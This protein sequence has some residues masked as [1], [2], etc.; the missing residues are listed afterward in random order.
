ML[1]IALE[2]AES[3]GEAACSIG[4]DFN[5]TLEGHHMES[6]LEWAGWIDLFKG[7]GGTCVSS[8]VRSAIDHVLASRAG[9]GLVRKA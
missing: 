6:A 3:L 9:R 7:K 1:T 8:G 5:I 4:G 2:C